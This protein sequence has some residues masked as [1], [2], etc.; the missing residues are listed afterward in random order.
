METNPA[1]L[2]TAAVDQ[3][4][5]LT[6]PAE[7]ARAITDILKTIEDDK[8]LKHTRATDLRTLRE[9]LTLREVSEQVDLSVGRIDQIVKGI[10]TGRRARRAAEDGT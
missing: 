4:L 5:A 6:D 3:A 9:T 1:A 10:V 8:R 7:R 2:A